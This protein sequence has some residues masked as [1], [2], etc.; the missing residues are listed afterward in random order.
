[1]YIVVNPTLK[2]SNVLYFQRRDAGSPMPVPLHIP[3]CAHTH[4]HTCPRQHTQFLPL[5]LLPPFL[6]FS[7]NMCRLLTCSYSILISFLLSFSLYF[8]F[9][10]YFSLL[11]LGITRLDFEVGI[12][13]YLS[14]HLTHHTRL[15]DSLGTL[16]S[17]KPPIRTEGMAALPLLTKIIWLCISETISF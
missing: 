13:L 8:L 3:S 1:M 7:T 17:S 11:N 16:A 12:L 14:Q 9:F 2:K 6:V 4:T 15:Q 10:C 5:Y